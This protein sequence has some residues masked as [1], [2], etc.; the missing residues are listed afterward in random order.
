[1]PAQKF[2]HRISFEGDPYAP[3]RIILDLANTGGELVDISSRGWEITNNFHHSFRQSQT[4]LPLPTPPESRGT[5]PPDQLR[6]LLN[7]DTGSGWRRILAWTISA[8]R[9]TGPYPILVITGPA[10]SGK[11]SSPAPSAP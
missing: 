5:P 2:D 8:I 11:S 4:T 10:R 7:L 9:P 1:M 6:K 3:S